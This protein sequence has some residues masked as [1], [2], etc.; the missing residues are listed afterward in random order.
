[1]L[2]IN[3][4]PPA[5]ETAE[6]RSASVGLLTC[7]SRPK[8]QHMLEKSTRHL[9]LAASSGGHGLDQPCTALYEP[10][11]VA[12]RTCAGNQGSGKCKFKQCGGGARGQARERHKC[13]CKRAASVQAG[14]V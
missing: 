5:A 12:G 11:L 2:T 13:R 10:P 8:N 3:Q 7:T 4:N 9:L 6:A 1:M 14:A